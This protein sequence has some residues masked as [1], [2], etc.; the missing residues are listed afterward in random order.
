[1]PVLNLPDAEISYTLS[2]QGAPVVFIQGVGVTGTGWQ[3]QVDEL[4]REFTCLSFDNRGI[5]RSR[6]QSQTLSIAQMAADTLALMDGA[7]FE[8][9]HVVGHSMGGVIAQELAL[10]APQR[11]KSLSLLCTFSQ[12][13]EVL[14]LTPRMLWLGL[15]SRLG[16]A[17]MR[18]RAFLHMLFSPSYLAG[19]DLDRLAAELEP[20]IGRDLA[21]QPPIVMQQLKAL[22]RHDCSARLKELAPIPTVIV[23][24]QH[25]SIARTLY[26]NRLARLIPGARYV[27][28]PDAS[29]GVPIQSP[30]EINGLLREHFRSAGSFQ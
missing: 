4:A 10:V 16:T 22:G 25:D 18:R 24:A 1:M 30:A 2:G 12:G 28:M 7:G 6:S 9:A 11:V 29:H 26:G 13:A 14:R 5:G 27:E 23:S 19:R 3:P 21:K 15:R 8:S 17:G 20:V